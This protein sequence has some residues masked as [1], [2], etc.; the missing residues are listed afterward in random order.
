MA[1]TGT[2]WHPVIYGAWTLALTAIFTF[3]LSIVCFPVLAWAMTLRPSFIHLLFASIFGISVYQSQIFLK[4]QELHAADP[5]PNGTEIL[6]LTTALLYY[7]IL[8]FIGLEGG[9]FVTGLDSPSF[10]LMFALLYPAWD[11]RTTKQALPL[12]VG[13][14][15]AFGLTVLQAVGLISGLV[16]SVLCKFEMRP[17]RY[18]NVRTILDPS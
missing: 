18:V 11:I 9:V 1:D 17:F 13:G 7:N 10:A 6:V 2:K 3:T 12:S 4:E 15:I 16:L 5:L 14:G 8:L